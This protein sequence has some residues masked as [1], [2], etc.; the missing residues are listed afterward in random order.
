MPW[1]KWVFAAFDSHFRSTLSINVEERKGCVRPT[2]ISASRVSSVTR[3]PILEVGKLA[4]IVDLRNLDAVTTK[5]D[6]FPRP[7]PFQAPNP[8]Y[9]MPKDTAIIKDHKTS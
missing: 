3:D 4:V 2:A 9:L 6:P 7:Y 5:T 1:R 8:L